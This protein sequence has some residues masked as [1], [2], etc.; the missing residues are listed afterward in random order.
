MRSPATGIGFCKTEFHL[1]ESKTMVAHIRRFL[2]SGSICR[3]II[4][5]LTSGTHIYAVTGLGTGSA[6]GP[7]G[8]GP[9]TKPVGT[10][11]Q[12]GTDIPDVNT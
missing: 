2:L 3:R 1:P 8:T 12:P 11:C 9:G 4:K 7:I 6:P 5:V 10:L